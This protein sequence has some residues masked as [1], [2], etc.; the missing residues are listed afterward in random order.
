MTLTKRSRT[1]VKYYF[2]REEP[3]GGGSS[4]SK[5][6]LFAMCLINKTDKLLGFSLYLLVGSQA[7]GRHPQIMWFSIIVLAFFGGFEAIDCVLAQRLAVPSR[8]MTTV[9]NRLSAVVAQKHEF[10]KLC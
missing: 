8:K 7:F 10:V 6:K 5:W 3:E 9:A 4:Y 1:L 2:P